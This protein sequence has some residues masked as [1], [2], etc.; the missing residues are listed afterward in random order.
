MPIDFSS[1][2][3]YTIDYVDL[4]KNFE[5]F[6]MFDNFNLQK[7]YLNQ[8]KIKLKNADSKIL[9][10]NKKLGEIL[11]AVTT[12]ES[13][14]QATIFGKNTIVI[15]FTVAPLVKLAEQN[16][17]NAIEIPLTYFEKS[18]EFVTWTP[19]SQ[20]DNRNLKVLPILLTHFYNA[21][22]FGFLLIDGNHRVSQAFKNH[23]KTIKALIIDPRY[24]INGNFF[25]S[26]F[27]KLFFIFQNELYYLFHCKK[28]YQMK[29]KELLE[30]SYLTN[31]QFNFSDVIPQL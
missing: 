7:N 26:E 10:K 15:N 9:K 24:M 1:M 13:F 18:R 22:T 25:K 30:R 11:N 31:E 21:R 16:K 19:I 14:Q 5:T 17:Q 6:P 20:T 28:Q 4:M 29:D 2:L 8:W 23:D 12:E 3:P 27:D